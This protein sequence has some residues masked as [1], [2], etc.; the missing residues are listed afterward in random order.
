MLSKQLIHLHTLCLHLPPVFKVCKDLDILAQSWCPAAGR[1]NSSC[2]GA[3]IGEETAGAGL[4]LRK[5]TH[6]PEN[7]IDFESSSCF[8]SFKLHFL[9]V[10]PSR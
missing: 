1:R 8:L 7:A 3:R 5:N 6:G 9:P 10:S 4:L 2:A